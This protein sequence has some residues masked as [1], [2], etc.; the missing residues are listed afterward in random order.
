MERIIRIGRNEL[1]GIISEA[2]SRVMAMEAV[3]VRDLAYSPKKFVGTFYD[4]FERRLRR[5]RLGFELADSYFTGD[6]KVIATLKNDNDD[7]IYV[8]DEWD[9]YHAGKI[10]YIET[11]FGRRSRDEY[12]LHEVKG[13][14]RYLCFNG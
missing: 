6:G 12:G 11:L 8:E 1:C 13:K 3:T 7:C 5:S 4:D 2:I 10:L 14:N 9:G